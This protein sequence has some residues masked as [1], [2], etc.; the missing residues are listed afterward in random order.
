M[1]KNIGFDFGFVYIELEWGSGI[2]IGLKAAFGFGERFYA[3][4]GYYAEN[5]AF[6]MQRGT[7]FRSA[8]HA[9]RRYFTY[10]AADLADQL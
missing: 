5:F 2:N 10:D 7:R 8:R 9:H 4:G 3:E 1:S 6:Q